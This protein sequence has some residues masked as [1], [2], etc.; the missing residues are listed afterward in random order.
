MYLAVRPTPPSPAH[1]AGYHGVPVYEPAPHL[2]AV[3]PYQVGEVA[4][5][6][7]HSSLLCSAT[8]PGGLYVSRKSDTCP[9]AP[10]YAVPVGMV[11]LFKSQS[12]WKVVPSSSSQAK[13]ITAPTLLCDIE[14]LV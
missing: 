9:I 12:M 11:G 5:A 7:I 2:P 4:A 8:Q 13:W 14:G 1:L 6:P 10:S 3:K